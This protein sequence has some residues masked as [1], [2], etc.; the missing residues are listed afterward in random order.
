MSHPVG[1]TSNGGDALPLP[2]VEPP[3]VG[4]TPHRATSLDVAQDIVP[5]AEVIAAARKTDEALSQLGM[6]LQQRAQLRRHTQTPGEEAFRLL[7]L[8]HTQQR[9]VTQPGTMAL[10]GMGL[11]NEET[12][13]AA[14]Q[15]LAAASASGMMAQQGYLGSKPFMGKDLL[16]R[17][18]PNPGFRWYSKNI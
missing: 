9:A 14:Q 15:V 8:H 7:S 12:M 18:I 1:S 13:F 3:I 4:D 2:D 17:C 5:D 10:T 6:T 16:Y 11:T